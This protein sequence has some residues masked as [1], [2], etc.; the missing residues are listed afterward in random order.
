MY[1]IEKPVRKTWTMFIRIDKYNCII[2]TLHDVI[3]DEI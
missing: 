3:Q 2:L 1:S